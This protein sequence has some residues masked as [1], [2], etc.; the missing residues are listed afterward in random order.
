MADD[1]V[2]WLARKL[3]ECPGIW[4]STTRANLRALRALP[5]PV[6]A[7][8]EG[9]VL[10]VRRPDPGQAADTGTPEEEAPVLPPE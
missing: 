1:W 3:K 2:V 4:F 6:E 5:F 10:F 9:G 7:M 8:E